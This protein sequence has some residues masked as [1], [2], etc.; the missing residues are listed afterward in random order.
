MSEWREKVFDPITTRIAENI[1]GNQLKLAEM[2][3]FLLSLGL[4][5]SLLLLTLVY[6]YIRG[7]KCR[8]ENV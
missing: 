7:L 8:R 1:L 4:W 6:K 5:N 3:W 2:H